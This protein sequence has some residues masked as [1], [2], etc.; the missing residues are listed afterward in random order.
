MIKIIEGTDLT[1]ITVPVD[2]YDFMLSKDHTSECTYISYLLPDTFN[3][4]DGEDLEGFSHPDDYEY[5]GEVTKDKVG[6]DC[7]SYVDKYNDGAY[8]DYTTNRPFYADNS[9]MYITLTKEESFYSRLA[10]NGFIDFD[11]LVIIKKTGNEKS[12]FNNQKQS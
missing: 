2:A 9:S 1:A 8:R 5:L 11:K 10:A 12:N 7:R 6:F 4:R 3:Y